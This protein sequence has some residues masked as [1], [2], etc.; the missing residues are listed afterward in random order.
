MAEHGAIHEEWDGCGGSAWF[1]RAQ[2]SS[3]ET[4]RSSTNGCAR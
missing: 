4:P 3:M 2:A 1:W